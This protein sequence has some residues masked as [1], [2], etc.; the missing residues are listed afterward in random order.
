MRK[1]IT[2]EIPGGW[3]GNEPGF[4]PAWP[5]VGNVVVDPNK[6]TWAIKWLSKRAKI[7]ST[8]LTDHATPGICIKYCLR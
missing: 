5:K 3:I 2:Y 4:D 6:I 8:S 1:V 7:I